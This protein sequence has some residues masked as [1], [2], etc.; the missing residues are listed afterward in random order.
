MNIIESLKI[1]LSNFGENYPNLMNEYKTNGMHTPDLNFNTWKG[2][3]E[4]IQA[5]EIKSKDSS[6]LELGCQMGIIPHFFKEHGF[7]DVDSTNSKIE[8]GTGLDELENSWRAMNLQVD[9]LHILPKEEFVL[10]K[11]YDYIIATST[12]ILWNSNRL[13]QIH[14]NNLYYDY[15]ILDKN[16]V[17]H[18]YF[19]PYDEEELKF[20]VTNIKKYLTPGGKAILHGLPFPYFMP[21]FKKELEYLED[22]T[23][24]ITCDNFPDTSLTSDLKQKT[25]FTYFIIEGDK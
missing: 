14:K 16:D 2:Q 19:V 24:I 25:L 4:M 17:A 6:I 21:Q 22:N 9:S 5:L 20:F 12:N 10:R 15:Y 23:T 18:T 13:L 11:K 3:A 7:T 1:H 8:A